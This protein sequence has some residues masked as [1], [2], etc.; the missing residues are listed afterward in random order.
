MAST[1]QHNRPTEA[2][3]AAEIFEI[4]D[5]SGNV[6]GTE[7]R[8]VVHKT[9]LLHKA[10][11]CFVFDTRGRLLIQRRSSHKSIGPNQWD[12]SVAEHLSPGETFRDAA[13]R[14]LQE[15]LG[16]AGVTLPQ[17]PLGPMHRRSL[18]VPGRYLDNELVE[19]YEL[20]GFSGQVTFNP[21]EVCEVKFIELPDLVTQMAAEPGKFTEWFRDELALLCFFGCKEQTGGGGTQQPSFAGDANLN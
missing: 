11:Y 19:S 14:G 21:A 16:V 1:I 7:L 17:Q 5:D 3:P 2:D 6:L 9:G 10:V 13:V 8:S 12:L 15:E 4:C 18:V 20:R